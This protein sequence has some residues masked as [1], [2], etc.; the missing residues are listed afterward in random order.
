MTD[1]ITT[2]DGHEHLQ[3]N[4]A[5][6]HNEN[7]DKIKISQNKRIKSSQTKWNEK[8]PTAMLSVWTFF[9]SDTEL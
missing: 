7:Y 2:D 1:Q 8:K 6:T 4:S 9:D 5:L 3:E